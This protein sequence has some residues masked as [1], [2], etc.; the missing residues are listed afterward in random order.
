M[1]NWRWRPG[2]GDGNGDGTGDGD[3]LALALVLAL[4]MVMARC[5]AKSAA[6]LMPE[7]LS[8]GREIVLKL[9]PVI[10]TQRESHRVAGGYAG[11]GAEDGTGAGAEDSAGADDG[12]GTD[13]DISWRWCWRWR[14]QWRPG[15]GNGNGDGA[16][17]ALA[18]A[19]ALVLALAL[20]R[21][22]AKSAANLAALMSATQCERFGIS[23][24]FRATHEVLRCHKMDSFFYE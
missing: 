23:N 11:T 17:L 2:A 13:A 19:L 10:A 6:E 7:C 4:A 8:L 15:A 20:A 1:Q 21:C 5:C 9:A 3:G 22:C 16:G 24:C 12:A 14:W 18:L